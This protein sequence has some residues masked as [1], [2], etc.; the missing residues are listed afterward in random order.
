MED[1]CLISIY[2]DFVDSSELTKV[3]YDLQYND[4]NQHIVLSGNWEDQIHDMQRRKLKALRQD[5]FEFQE[6]PHAELETIHKFLTVCRQA[7]GL[8]LNISLEKLLQLSS[9]L[10]N[11]YEVF[12]V[13]REGKLSAVCITVNV[14]TS[15]AYY[16]LAG[17]S[18]L[19]RSHSPMVLLIAGMVTHYHS[20]GYKIFDLGVSSYEG[21]PQE[22]LRLFKERMGAHETKK[23][24]LVKSL[25]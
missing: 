4:I 5:G 20:K 13:H 16:Y 11:A 10:P 24:T 19:F 2:S 22:T 12:G 8:Q 9:V 21:Q 23:P 17:T 14:T 1:G 25:R 7:Q 15:T 6:I 18:P 3:G